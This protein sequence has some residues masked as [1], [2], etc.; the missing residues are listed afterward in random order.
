M[1]KT[2]ADEALFDYVSNAYIYRM[3]EAEFCV[4]GNH[5]IELFTALFEKSLLGGSKFYRHRLLQVLEL[6]RGSWAMESSDDGRFDT[7]EEHAALKALK[8]RVISFCEKA[9]IE[10]KLTTFTHRDDVDE[11]E[12]KI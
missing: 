3:D 11:H 5:D 1:T 4:G 8:Q 2:K 12:P 9:G 7:T 10:H 6:L